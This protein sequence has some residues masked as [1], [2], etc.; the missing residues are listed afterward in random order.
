M[1]GII[2]TC[3]TCGVHLTVGPNA[4]RTLFCPRCCGRVENPAGVLPGQVPRPVI[5]LEDQTR[6]DQGATTVT[7]VVSAVLLLFGCVLAFIGPVFRPALLF[8]VLLVAGLVVHG[9]MAQRNSTN[10]AAARAWGVF[11]IVL[12]VFLWV[13]AIGVGV[14]LLILGL[15]AAILLSH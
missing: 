3:P 12:K 15:C 9:L 2:L 5:P 14:V 13:A 4:P 1:N 7:V 10:P 6:G 11:G 8:L